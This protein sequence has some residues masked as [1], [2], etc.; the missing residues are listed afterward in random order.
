METS[1]IVVNGIMYVTTSFNQVYALDAHTGEQLW[2]YKHAIGPITTFCC[3][4]NNRG[5]AAY[6]DMV[7]MGTLDAKL[8]ALDAKTGNEVWQT[9]IA[10][11]ALGYSET[12]APTVAR[13]QSP[14]R[15]QRR[16]IRH[17][18]LRQGL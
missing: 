3:G 11:P 2:Y 8:V 5:V 12:M 17:P 10:D 13:R 7:Y 9:D 16:R 1:P 14:H 4:P 6:D 15:H 18:W